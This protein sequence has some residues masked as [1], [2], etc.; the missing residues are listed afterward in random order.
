MMDNQLIDKI[1]EYDFH[2][3]SEEDKELLLSY[4]S[5]EEEF[6]QLKFVFKQVEK[7]NAESLEPRAETK[8]SLDAIFDAQH[9]RRNAPIWY[10]SVL[11]VIYPKDK[12]VYRRP[13]V[14]LAAIALLVLMVVPIANRM[15]LEPKKNELAMNLSVEDSKKEMKPSDVTEKSSLL[16]ENDVNTSV[17][18]QERIPSPLSTFEEPVVDE[19]H[20]MDMSHAEMVRNSAPVMSQSATRSVADMVSPHPDGIYTGERTVTYS[21]NAS[22]QPAVLDLLTATF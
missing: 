6:E 19:L 2:S 20:E 7:I 12:A 11:T 10:N 18:S 8:Q 5:N 3:L 13:L 22:K 15:N 1:L 17:L 14:Q 9:G 4:C 16:Q 21:M